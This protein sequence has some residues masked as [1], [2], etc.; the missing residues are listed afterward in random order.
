MKLILNFKIIISKQY[1]EW[2]GVL[3]EFLAAPTT[4]NGGGEGGSCLTIGAFDFMQRRR[5][6]QPAD[7]K[8]PM[9]FLAL[10]HPA[11]GAAGAA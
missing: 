9:A 5:R 1:W 2:G 4:S 7:L 10:R 3:F 6:L 8:Q 11:V